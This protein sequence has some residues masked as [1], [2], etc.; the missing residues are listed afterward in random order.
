MR[1]SR[2]FELFMAIP[3]SEIL[4]LRK[5]VD[6]PF[7]NQREHV[8]QLLA[9]LI[10]VRK[11]KKA[12]PERKIA[13]GQL[14]PGQAYDDHKLRL[15]MSLLHK[16]IEQYL[17]WEQ[18]NRESVDARLKLARA[19]RDLNLPR[20][21]KSTI[22]E[23]ARQQEKQGLRHADYY[24]DRYTWYL[25]QYRFESEQNRMEDL[26]LEEVHEN[27]DI[28]YITS[29]LRQI[30]FSLSHQSIYKKSYDFG[31]LS[32]IL[33]H[34]SAQELLEIPAISVYYYCYY[35]LTQP[36]EEQHFERFKT[37]I[38]TFQDQFPR[39]EVRD[40]FLLAA[41]YCIR[42]MNQGAR[43]F[44]KEGLS[45]YREGLQNEVLLLNG[46]L[47]RFTY[48]NIVAKA[49]IA[50]EFDWAESFIE[51]YRDRLETRYQ[52]N[53][54]AFNLAWLAYERKDYDKALR[55]I[56]QAAFDDLLLNLSAKTIAM[57]I[58]YELQAFDLLYSHLDAMRQFIG[59]KDIMVYHQRNYLNTIR[60]VKKL[61]D[62]P[63]SNRAV[64]EKL[65]TEINTT[66][67]VAEKKWLLEQLK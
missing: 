25:E 7:F 24:Q 64:R 39:D 37:Q 23:V 19:Y 26:H 45:I 56:N 5:F 35:T 21:F 4:A 14:F 60:F 62:L 3:S 61:L 46:I 48:R 63:I 6:S 58:Y 34:I 30:C 10:D 12:L 43:H 57:K 66:D 53:A 16:I 31:L 36:D 44:A 54:Y 29:K 47:S 65:Q 15:S 18:L 20:H 1:K 8:K 40:L 52:D 17:I 49:I 13:F 9:Y 42:K 59:R 38:L 2:L 41:N 27:L 32:A 28:A 22:N 33:S 51:A 11:R 50:R 55:L 67:V